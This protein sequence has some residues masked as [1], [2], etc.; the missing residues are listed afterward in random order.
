MK[1]SLPPRL[2]IGLALLAALTFH[3]TALSQP[4]TNTVTLLENQKPGTTTWQLTN[5]ALN[6]EIEGYASLTSVNRGGQINFLVNT[7]NTTYTLQV[8]RVGWYGGAGGRSMFGPVT[9]PG[10]SQTI[11]TPAPG[12]GLI[13]CNWTNPYTLNIPST[14]G[15]PTDWASGAYLVKLTG[16]QDGKQSY[17]IFTVRD[18]TRS[19][20]LLFQMSVTTYQAYNTWGGVSLYGGATIVSFNRPYA[21]PTA[22]PSWKG[23][24]DFWEWECNLLRWLEREG[25]DVSYCTSVDTHSTTNLLWSHKA[26]LSVGH[27]EYWTYPMR[28]NVQAARDRGVNLAILSANTCFWQMRFQPSTIDGAPNRDVVCYKATV[29][30]V[31]NTSSNYLTTVNYRAYPVLDSESSFLGVEFNFA[32]VNSDM[33]VSDPTHWIYT[34]TGVVAGQRLPGLLG[35]EVDATNMYSPAGM[36][37]ACTSPYLEPGGVTSY[38]LALANSASYTAPSGAMVF[39]AGTMQL[40]WGL[41]DINTPA[42]HQSCQNVVAQHIARNVLARMI[43]QP[44]PSPNFFYRTDASTSGNWKPSYGSEGYW[45]PGDSTNLP[46]YAA[47]SFTGAVFTNYLASSTD[48]RSVQHS[49]TTG[50]YLSG[51]SSPTN[52]TVDLNV[53]D[54]TNHLVSFYF[55]DWNQAGRTQMVEVL[56]AATSNLL[57]R[58]IISGFANGQWWSWQING[59]VQFR[60]TN[61]SG[62]NCVANALMFGSAATATFVCEDPVTQGNWKPYYGSD[63]QS[64]ASAPSQHN[65]SYGFITGQGGPISWPFTPQDPR[66]FQLYGTTNRVLAAVGFQAALDVFNIQIYDNALHQLAVYCVDGDQ[67]GR[68]EMLTLVSASDNKILDT[69]TVTNFGGGK[70]LVWNVRGSVRLHVQ[71]RGPFSSALSGIFLGPP[72]QPPSVSFTSLTNLEEFDLPT[73][74]VLSVNATD[75]DDYVTQVTY[76]TNGVPLA[77]VTNAPFTFVWTNALV[78]RYDVSAVALD[79]RHANASSGITTIFVDPPTNYQTP[80]VHVDSPT[81][82]STIQLP[83]NLTLSASTI[84]TSAPIVS[85]QFQ[86][87]GAPYGPPISAPPY[88]QTVSNL[89]AGPHSVRAVAVDAYGVVVTSP[90]VTVNAVEPPTGMAFR[91]NDAMDSGSWI[92]NY[93]SDGYIIINYATNLPSYAVAGPIGNN[94]YFW[95]T[96]T[97][98]PRALQKPNASD[99]FAGVWSSYTNF[100]LDVNLLDG[101]RHR[102]TL[103][104]LDWYNQGGV[105]TVRLSDA[106]S[107]TTLDTR[108]ISNFNN[109]VYLVWDVVGH[110]RFTFTRTLGFQAPL[111]GVFFDP[112][113]TSPT[114]S[115]L[116][117]AAGSSV[118]DP[119]NVLISAFAESGLTNLNRVE[120]RA[121]GTL[122]GVSTSGSPYTYTWTNPP[123]G[124]YTL[125]ARVVDAM[126]SNTVSAPALLTVEATAAA[127]NF[128]LVDTNHQG[129]WTGT[130]GTD[131]YVVAGDNTNAPPYLLSSENGELLTWASFTTDL[132]AM[133]HSLGN[134]RVA[135]AWYGYT[136]MVLDVKFTDTTYHRLSLYCLNW[137]NSGGA[138]TVS[139]L[140]NVSG[141]TLDQETL[142]PFS[143]GVYEVWDVKGH[144]RVVIN[145]AGTAPA[146]LSAVFVDPSGILPGIAIT[147]IPSQTMFQANT[148]IP[149]I[150]YAA[151]D[152]NNVSRVDFY[153]GATYLGSTSNG[154]PFAF[155]WTNAP[156]GLR[157]LVAQEVGPN[158]WTNS[159]PVFIS[160]M[161]SN[162]TSF[163]PSSLLPDGTLQLN[164]SAPAG[165]PVVLLYATNLGPTAV[166]TPLMTNVPSANQFSITISD[167]TKYPRR[168]YR[169]VTTP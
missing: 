65:P 34:N 31:F 29:D 111:T 94:S 116:S 59:H 72:N 83:I 9:V 129:S 107:G 163:M 12:T 166:W 104:C 25:Y 146:Y 130:Y 81:P 60:F 6:S 89:Y 95:A 46:A 113:R 15:D 68:A 169:F 151:P 123:P 119:T 8:F 78:G 122:L 19:T 149:L 43:N 148:S 137:Y 164:A 79:S 162:S 49:S 67:S 165:K 24:G 110:V 114:V 109:G 142:P 100:V 105:E 135:A 32:G 3:W 125:A 40:G 69:R 61:L 53:S 21:T 82:N 144:V 51:F 35:Y 138:E 152:P 58:R 50:G 91:N 143:N 88:T 62:P 41:D 55:W 33:V 2:R 157:S 5:P 16:G 48:S 150:A 132:R 160:I 11:P 158:G 161:S 87:D 98:D 66:A 64:L 37:I 99:R 39:A 7:T 96:S 26:F 14:P 101:N 90:G 77:T 44:P 86:L 73:N 63:G 23:V 153:D 54:G 42:L 141:A 126:G 30:P 159:T 85:V 13:E 38:T 102:I 139:L 121:N 124:A 167:P 118:A 120:F 22:T 93:G 127:A 84:W 112:P 117:P 145:R 10:Y 57:D 154:P 74:I 76:F 136:N 36:Q 168:Y 103:Y 1:R 70:Y 20:D 52:F 115:L 131:G 17:I 155:V 147:N 45:L 156:V 47:L 80:T 75:P 134:D 27:D 28:W 140:D 71:N 128:V 18:D 106:A 97:S 92:G 4:F 108:S 56:D 133:Q